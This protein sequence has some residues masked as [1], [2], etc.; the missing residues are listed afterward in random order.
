MGVPPDDSKL[1]QI[2]SLKKGAA[3]SGYAHRCGAPSRGMS[4][5]DERRHSSAKQVGRFL[6]RRHLP[7]KQNQH[8]VRF[9]TLSR[10]S[11]EQIRAE[12]RAVGVHVDP[13]GRD[14]E[15][16]GEDTG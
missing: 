5:A 10:H 9:L 14:Q 1:S 16:R 12:G 6:T 13:A 7:S 2:P 3:I 4:A 11:V 15:A 8:A